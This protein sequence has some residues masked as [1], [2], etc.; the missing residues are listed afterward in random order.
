VARRLIA[1]TGV[2]VASQRARAELA[3]VITEEDDLV[4]AAI[5][6]AELRKGVGDL[7]GRAV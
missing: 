3:A 1:D 2:L 5:T 7:P 6:V 4:V